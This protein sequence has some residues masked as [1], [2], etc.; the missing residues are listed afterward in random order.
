MTL[1]FSL[2]NLT[3]EIESTVHLCML[4]SHC[5]LVVKC[6]LNGLLQ[7]CLSLKIIKSLHIISM[8]NQLCTCSIWFRLFEV[9]FISSF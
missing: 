8:F 3:Q 6:L 9:T 4:H 7:V 2:P 1:E 5:P